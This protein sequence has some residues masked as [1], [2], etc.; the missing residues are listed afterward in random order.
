MEGT[1]LYTALQSA[2]AEYAKT[3]GEYD[4][5]RAALTELYKDIKDADI[6]AEL[7]ADLVGDYLFTDSEFISHLS[8]QNRN[9]FQKIYD[10]I[11]YLVKVATAGSKEARELQR[12]KRAFDKAYKESGTT[13]TEA[14][15]YALSKDAYGN[16]FVDITEDIFGGNDGESVARTIQRVIAERF[17]NLIDVHGQK[18]Q[19][20]KTTNDEFRR[21][22]S[23]SALLKKSAEAYNDK[24]RTIA[25]A[26]EILAAAKNWIGEE[27]NHTRKDDIIEFARG[28]VMYRVGGNGYVAD[29][30]VGT[31]KN[32]AAVLYDLV[33]IYE[34]EIAEA[35]VTMASHNDSQRRRDASAV[36]IIPQ[37]GENVN[38]KFSISSDS[39]G[40]RGNRYGNYNVRG[41]DVRI[42]VALAQDGVQDKNVRQNVSPIGE[43]AQQ[44]DR[45][46]NV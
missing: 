14:A 20:N 21:S 26:D 33:N 7:T 12:V 35:P 23:A 45:L 13:N 2:I 8:T 17:N 18:I 37:D 4:T 29:V 28:N 38:T 39:D 25:N 11:K 32:G 9:V 22:E 36:G 43:T 15:K 1:D 40:K 31:R 16:V 34:T 19:I 41:E 6:D 10:E 30:I 44:N 42:G 5:R 3:K 27:L 46:Y 24:L